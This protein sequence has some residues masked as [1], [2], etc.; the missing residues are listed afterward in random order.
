[1]RDPRTRR[2][3][4]KGLV[5]LS[6]AIL[7]LVLIS[8]CGES[9]PDDLVYPA[10]TDPIAGEAPKQSPL[11]LDSPGQWDEV[12][13]EF[14][15]MGGKI[16]DTASLP[17]RDVVQ[18]VLDEMFGTPAH[19]RVDVS[20]ASSD[21]KLTWTK[22]VDI[23]LNGDKSEN[24]TGVSER[25]AAKANPED[26][27]DRLEL[28]QLTLEEAYL[29]NAG[30]DPLRLN[31]QTL[32]EG[33]KLY[34][35][36]CLHC[37]GLTGDGHGP[38]GLWVNPHPRDYRRGFFKF[39]ST[40][41]SG[42]NPI[43][44]FKLGANRRPLRSDLVHTMQQG[45]DGTS[46]PSFGQLSEEDLEKIASY[47]IHLSVRGEVELL[48][49]QDLDKSKEQGL[50]EKTIRN[51][52]RDSLRLVLSNWLASQ[53]SGIQVKYPFAD[54]DKLPQT[55]RDAKM[56][57]SIKSGFQLFKSANCIGCHVDYGRQFNYK[58]D[59]WG[60]I[61]RPADVTAGI[62]RGG[63]R[64]VDLYYRL[65]SGL[66]GT[67]MPAFLTGNTTVAQVW[68]LVHF[69]QAVPY[70]AMLPEDVRKEVYPGR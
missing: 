10:R 46:M 2:N 36:Q 59:D 69:L 54:W 57:A 21:G 34:R 8:G 61:I 1:M 30:D 50:S 25:K 12:R 64:P 65:H 56:Q 23:I 15:E 32:A 27:E 41:Q 42:W 11:Q 62:Y 47:V 40:S 20:K 60:N 51:K 4:L 52:M 19:P 48:I 9:Y 58:W 31:E 70:P 6:A 24:W 53:G 22:L 67:P 13:V 3:L 66:N 39:T 16:I 37:H 44:G 28:E 29:K 45:I 17:N 26:A 14:K 63:R 5:G 38:T 49:L 35:R 68:D 33:S 43:L 55:E 7:A 18:T